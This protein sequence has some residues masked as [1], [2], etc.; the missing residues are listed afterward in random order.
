M[1]NSS[2]QTVQQLSPN[3]PKEIGEF[4]LVGRLYSFSYVV[5]YLAQDE[6]GDSFMIKKYDEEKM[7]EQELAFARQEVNK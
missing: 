3:D 6:K 4:R 7:S 1:G 5:G 2:S